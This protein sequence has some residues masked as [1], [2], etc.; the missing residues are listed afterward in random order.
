MPSMITAALLSEIVGDLAGAIGADNAVSIA[1]INKVVVKLMTLKVA[2]AAAAVPVAAP[3]KP[4]GVNKPVAAANFIVVQSDV[5]VMLGAD[6]GFK[7][8]AYAGHKFIRPVF[9]GAKSGCDIVGYKFEPYDMNNM[10]RTSVIYDA[11][12]AANNKPVVIFKLSQPTAN[13][14]KLDEGVQYVLGLMNKHMGE[15]G[16]VAEVSKIISGKHFNHLVVK[17]K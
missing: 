1:A 12:E 15:R 3:P 7:R 13:A 2:T 6:K 11:L 14:A 16:P 4:A 5:A 9:C 10:D 17:C 8:A